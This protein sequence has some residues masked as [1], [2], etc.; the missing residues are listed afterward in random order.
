VWVEDVSPLGGAHLQVKL[1]GRLVID[2]D[3]PDQPRDPDGRLTRHNG[4]Y[5]CAVPAGPHEIVV[6]NIGNDWVYVTY[7]LGGFGD[8][9]L[10]LRLLALQTS[11]GVWFWAQ[12]TDHIWPRLR[13]KLP[14]RPTPSGEVAF[15]GLADGRY[16]VHTFDTQTGATSQGAVVTVRGGRLA[17]PLPR[18]RWDLAAYAARE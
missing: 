15:A 2:Q 7:R 3:M 6:D 11:R 4:L 10:R 1:D 9:S 14:V 17:I 18:V 16:T 5:Q 13:E 8:P 12:N